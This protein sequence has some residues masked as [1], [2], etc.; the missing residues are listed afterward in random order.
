[1]YLPVFNFSRW[2]SKGSDAGGI[3][4]DAGGII[5]GIWISIGNLTL[6]PVIKN[7]ENQLRFDKVTAV[8]W[9]FD[10]WRA[11]WLSAAFVR[12]MFVGLSVCL[13]VTLVSHA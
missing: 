4:T 9:W 12:R 1:M 13:S 7:F 3:I 6:F 11:K 8:S 10:F 2:C 5:T